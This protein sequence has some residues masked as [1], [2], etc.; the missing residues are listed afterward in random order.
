[1]PPRLRVGGWIPPYQDVPPSPWS[2]EAHS[3]GPVPTRNAEVPDI[4]KPYRR[5]AV[6]IVAA[7]VAVVAFAG[8]ATTR[9]PRQAPDSAPVVGL[10]PEV[11]FPP[12]IPVL[13]AE[14]EASA[15]PSG[16]PLRTSH[17]ST[18]RPTV[19]WTETGRHGTSAKPSH[20]AVDLVV[21]TTI[22]L[23]LSDRPGF[24]VRHRNFLG[25]VDRI[26]PGSSDLDR[27]DSRFTV[28]AGLAD[29]GCVS[30]ESVNY[31]HYFLRH[32][33]FVIHLDRRD[34]T[35]LF[36]AD[37]TFCPVPRQGGAA[38]SLQS[39]NFPGWYVTEENA[40]LVLAPAAARA[41]AFVVR[42]AL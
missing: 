35:A 21:G 34:R 23:E 27:A 13:P 28:R 30:L 33:N 10:L 15:A 36:A 42:P 19:T 32:R 9:R 24:R 31:P 17:P 41:T 2:A 22:G 18:R 37:A 4:A 3:I 1:M 11:S 20:P 25:R 39:Y 12:P 6:L 5:Y 16:T 29:D 14:P 8:L 26:G 40:R 7:V 38:L